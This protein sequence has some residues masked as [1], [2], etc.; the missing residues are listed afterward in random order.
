MAELEEPSN[1]D[2]LTAKELQVDTNE[3]LTV[4]FY[5][6]LQEN[7]P[8]KKVHLFVLTELSLQLIDEEICRGVEAEGDEEECL[9]RRM[10]AEAHL[11]YI[12]T[13]HHKH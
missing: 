8:A 3:S 5:L 6:N 13:Q 7:R 2:P 9:K 11:D 4:S 1:G 12:Y 10:I